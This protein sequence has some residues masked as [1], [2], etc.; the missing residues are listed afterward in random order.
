MK[1]LVTGARG[2]LGTDVVA[3]LSA[4]G[5]HEV[6][7]TGAADLDV[8]S[9]QAVLSAVTGWRPDLIVNCAAMTAVD[10]CEA[11]PDLAY[12]LNALGPRH[13]A[14]G[15]ARVGAHLVHVSTDY[16]FDG[17]KTGAYLEWDAPNPRSVYGASKLA[18]EREVLTVAPGATVVRTSWVCGP[19]GHNM[20]K[21]AL[22]L[23]DA[24][25]PMRFVD[26]QHGCPTFTAD[27]A[28]AVVALGV[29]RRPGLFHV[30]NQ[31]PTTWYRFVCDVLAAAGR[32]PGVVTPITTA[33]YPLPAPRPANSVLD[34]AA[35]RLSDLP[36]LAD[37]H[38]PLARTVRALLA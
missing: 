19:H 13:L 6:A 22:R 30:T 27:L 21:T 38:E 23:A 31:G 11:E 4:P 36:L 15:A 29:D 9:R 25:G 18:G 26:D 10:R 16:V 35:L 12:R 8:G 1:V 14:E 5:H 33:D 28:A 37:H 17:T 32:D 24:G 7:A 3:R 34:N 20:V 2:Q